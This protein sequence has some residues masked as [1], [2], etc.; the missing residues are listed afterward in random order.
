[1]LALAAAIT[2]AVVS[3]PGNIPNEQTNGPRP[4]SDP[5][6]VPDGKVT[7]SGKSRLSINI[8]VVSDYRFRGISQAAGQAAVQASAE[9]VSPGG[10]Y[11]G[12]WGSTS[13]ASKQAYNEVDVYGGYRAKVVDADFDL[14]VVS[15][16][17]PGT[18]NVSS[19]EIYTSAAH[20][21]G[22]SELKVGIS[23][24]PHQDKLGTG[25]GLYLFSEVVQPLTAIPVVL[26]GHLGRETG[27]NTVT[28]YDKIDWLLGADVNINHATIS[29][30]WVDAQYAGRRDT[31]HSAGRA[32]AAV[33]FNF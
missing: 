3:T 20:S 4:N 32:V 29:L 26:R 21:I 9:V 24:T 15:Y 17:Y 16:L 23:Y 31:R 11:V 6:A 33:A 22:N 27:V 28:G 8:S 30:A 7:T 18:G 10:L 14:G 12:S 13:R 5:E 1:M 19:T 2:L 25:D